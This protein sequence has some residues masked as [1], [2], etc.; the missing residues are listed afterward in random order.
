MST[1]V[2]IM[3]ED[4]ILQTQPKTASS[5]RKMERTVNCYHDCLTYFSFSLSCRALTDEAEFLR[6]SCIDRSNSKSQNC[7]CIVSNS[8][9]V[10]VGRFSVENKK[11]P[12]NKLCSS[13][14]QEAYFQILWSFTSIRIRVD[15]LWT[16]V[17]FIALQAHLL[18]F[19]SF[20]IL[21]A[22]C[23]ANDYDTVDVSEYI[24]H[25]QVKHARLQFFALVD[26][27]FSCCS[28]KVH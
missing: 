5:R 18:S 6:V 9:E 7:C 13:N 24:D 19:F 25:A 12:L 8:F 14:S 10:V 3:L 20:P 27:M 4:L 28:S 11:R 15:W 17:R 23:A 22:R 16:G 26:S 21:K 2:T 1:W